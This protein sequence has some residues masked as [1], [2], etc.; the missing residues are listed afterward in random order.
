MT[1]PSAAIVDHWMYMFGTQNNVLEIKYKVGSHGLVSDNH[2]V[3]SEGCQRSRDAQP[4][5]AS[6]GAGEGQ[7]CGQVGQGRRDTPGRAL[8]MGMK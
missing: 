2:L 6:G 8:N 3:V 1:Y 5:R 4:S 7:H